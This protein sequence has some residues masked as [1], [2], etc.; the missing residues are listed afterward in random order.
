[1][2]SWSSTFRTNNMKIN[3]YYNCSLA[4]EM[5]LIADAQTKK[6]IELATIQLDKGFVVESKNK[7]SNM[8]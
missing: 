6:M 3:Y 7:P 2:N 1:M 8:P 5:I 4:D